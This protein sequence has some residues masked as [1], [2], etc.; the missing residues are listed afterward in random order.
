MVPAYVFKGQS[1]KN[2]INT[3]MLCATGLLLATSVPSLAFAESEGRVLEEVIVTAE[4]RESVVQDTAISISAF[5]GEMMDDLGISGA[6][7]IANYTPGM[8]YNASPNRIFIRGIGR[9]ENS[10]GSEPARTTRHTL[11]TKC[12]RRC[13]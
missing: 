6:A 3:G 2:M 4:K 8:T 13:R 1:M 9:V 10:L 5:D 11:W 7:D 12:H